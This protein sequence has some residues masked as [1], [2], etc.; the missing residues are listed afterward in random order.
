LSVVNG[1]VAS[2]GER[3]YCLG[4]GIGEQFE[5]FVGL[6]VSLERT[7]IRFCLFSNK[8]FGWGSRCMVEE[9]DGFAIEWGYLA[10]LGGVMMFLTSWTGIIPELKVKWEIKKMAS[11][12]TRKLWESSSVKTEALCIAQGGGRVVLMDP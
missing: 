6:R 3:I 9:S 1:F 8:D 12:L 10:E 11:R 5:K 2:G 4:L 7:R